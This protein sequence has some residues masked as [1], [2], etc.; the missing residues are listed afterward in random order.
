MYF[1]FQLYR[2]RLP[3]GAWGTWRTVPEDS[4]AQPGSR[5]VSR[6]G[7]R[8]DV[9]SMLE[10]KPES[11]AMGGRGVGTAKGLVSFQLAWFQKLDG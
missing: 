10:R 9:G 8:R 2:A 6:G 3:T 5:K 7:G 1:P 11:T 4:S